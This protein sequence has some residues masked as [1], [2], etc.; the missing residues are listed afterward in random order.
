MDSCVYR[1]ISYAVT[2]WAY[3]IRKWLVLLETLYNYTGFCAVRGSSTSQIAFQVT[4]LTQQVQPM[5]LWNN[6]RNKIWFKRCFFTSKDFS[7]PSKR[8]PTMYMYSSISPFDFV[9]VWSIQTNTESLC[10]RQDDCSGITLL[11]AKTNLVTL[12]T[13]LVSRLLDSQARPD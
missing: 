2:Q 1:K 7:F 11:H 5:R 6:G 9:I 13:W 12:Y 4:P 10:T 8:T 3:R